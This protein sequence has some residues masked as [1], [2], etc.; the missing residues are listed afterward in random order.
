MYLSA[1]FV[2][3][4]FE[5]ASILVLGKSL[6]SLEMH[7]LGTSALR[8]RDDLEFHGVTLLVHGEA[9][10]D[11]FGASDFEL[12]KFRPIKPHGHR[13]LL[14]AILHLAIAADGIAFKN[15]E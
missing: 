1:V 7:D 10:L 11:D 3:R 9:T 12:N 8:N 5:V 13:G 2:N 15:S 6:N 14:P 4:T